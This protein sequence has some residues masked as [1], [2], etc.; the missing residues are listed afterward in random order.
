MKKISWNQANDL[1][2]NLRLTITAILF[3]LLG[4]ILLFYH[5]CRPFHNWVDVKLE[6]IF[7]KKKEKEE[8]FRV[9]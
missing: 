3:P 7:N 8:N 6:K 2:R 9:L 1:W 5:V 4:G